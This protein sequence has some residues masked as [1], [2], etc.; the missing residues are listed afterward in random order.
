MKAYSNEFRQRVLAMCD[1][2]RSTR[3][4][5][6]VF[7]VCE[8]WVRRIKQ[9]RREEDRVVALPGGGRRRGHFDAARLSQ[10]EAWLREQ[11]DATLQALC[12]RVTDEWQLPC[13]LMAV[14]RAVQKLGWSLK[15]N[16]SCGRA[17]SAGG[18]AEAFELPHR[19]AFR[20]YRFAG[21]PR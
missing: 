13:S 19:A 4:V 6:K 10:L 14:C 2:G 16:A 8:S 21:F 17:G 1:Q 5:A 9:V 18:C 12:R 3:E 15:K 7:D 20:G 11:P